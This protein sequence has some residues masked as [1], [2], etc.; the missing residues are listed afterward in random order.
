MIPTPFKERICFLAQEQNEQRTAEYPQAGSLCCDVLH[1][2][3]NKCILGGNVSA[4]TMSE[5]NFSST[6]PQVERCQVHS[7][8]NQVKMRVKKSWSHH[9][10]SFAVYE[11]CI[12]RHPV[13]QAGIIADIYNLVILHSECCCP[14]IGSPYTSICYSEQRRSLRANAFGVG[15]LRVMSNHK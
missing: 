14:A 13:L 7:S 1:N 5:G 4:K 10:L 12:L 9:H 2:A 15:E 3:R 11:A 8:V 6:E